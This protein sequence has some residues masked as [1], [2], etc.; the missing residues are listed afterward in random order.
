MSDFAELAF[1]PEKFSGHVRLFPLPNLVMFPGVMQPLHIFEPRYREMLEDALASDRL[2]AMA[3][4]TAGWEKQYEGRPPIAPVACLGRVATFQQ[5]APDRYNVLLL[6]L[7]RVR[8]ARELP[9]ARSFREADVDVLE[10]EYPAAAAAARP[11]LQKTLVK[12]F[13]AILP[14]LQHAQEQ[15]DQ[16]LSGTIPLGMLTDIVAYALDLELAAKQQLLSETNVD[17]R[18]TMLLGHL[19]SAR[20]DPARVAKELF[21]PQFSVN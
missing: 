5:Q 16:L 20:R 13:K 8:L 10:D 7:R 6:G 18:A 3:L 19:D 17:L 4:L 11:A 1:K 14:Q 15:L 9:A 2:I 12:K 21:P